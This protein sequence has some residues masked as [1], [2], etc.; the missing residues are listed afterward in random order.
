MAA[1]TKGSASSAPSSASS[2][3]CCGTRDSIV[4]ISDLSS[5]SG[6]RSTGGGGTS[7]LQAAA[8]ATPKSAQINLRLIARKCSV[9]YLPE[10]GVPERQEGKTLYLT[11]D[12]MIQT[13]HVPLAA[14]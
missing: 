13:P 4:T 12:G 6:R 1:V 7:R 5:T 11:A 8:R 3:A 2:V 10:G 14:L 9:A